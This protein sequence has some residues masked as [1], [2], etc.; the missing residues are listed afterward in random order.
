MRGTEE[1]PVWEDPSPLLYP[2]FVDGLPRWKQKRLL[3]Q[4]FEELRIARFSFYEECEPD[5]LMF[6][7]GGDGYCATCGKDFQSE[8][9]FCSTLCK[10]AFTNLGKTVCR[11]CGKPLDFGQIIQHHIAYTDEKTFTV[12]RSCHGKIHSGG[13]LPK[14][15]PIDRRPK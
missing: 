13:K 1:V 12:C 4:Q 8:G 9:D 15:R 14:L 7:D 3:R 11:V 2:I 5:G 10:E 6:G